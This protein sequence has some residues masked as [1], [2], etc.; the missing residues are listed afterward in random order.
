MS[1][2]EIFVVE[3]A[4]MPKTGMQFAISFTGVG[5]FA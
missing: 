4:F 2:S 3:T 5:L 1:W